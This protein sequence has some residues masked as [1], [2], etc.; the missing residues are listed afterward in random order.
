MSISEF[1]DRHGG[2]SKPPYDSLN[3]ALHV[4]D[5]PDDVL[6]NRQKVAHPAVYMNQTHSDIVVEVRDPG[7]VDADAVITRV[8]GL[9]LAVLV[10][11]CIPLL[12]RSPHAVAAVHVGRR[13]LLNG[14]AVKA[15]EKMGEGPISALLGPSICGTCYEVGGDVFD[16]VVSRHPLAAARSVRGTQSLDL[17]RALKEVLVQHNVHVTVDGRCTLEDH[18]LFSYR[19]DGVTGRQA[20]LI[21]L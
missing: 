15:L 18:E 14:I 20:G 21:S 3:L 17:T 6:R 8:P 1:S 5:D 11:D 4:G 19:R 13:G 7:T 2:L 12:L 16:E 9:V 10:A